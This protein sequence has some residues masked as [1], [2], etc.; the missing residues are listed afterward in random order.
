MAVRFKVWGVADLP[1]GAAPLDDDPVDVTWS[2]QVG[3]PLVFGRRI[4]VQG[5]HDSLGTRAVFRGHA[6]LQIAGNALKAVGGL[7]NHGEPSSPAVLVAGKSKVGVEIREII[8]Q[9]IQ[10]VAF[11]FKGGGDGQAVTLCEETHETA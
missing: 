9:F 5:G 4:F 2:Q 10:W 11:I 7:A 6:V 3:N 1:K 8:N